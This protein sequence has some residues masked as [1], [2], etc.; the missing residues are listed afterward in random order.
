MLKN[1][2][3]GL[4]KEYADKFLFGFD[5][6]KL[7]MSLLTGNVD[8]KNVNIRPDA[9]N[10][11][12]NEQLK[13]PLSLKAGL[14]SKIHVKVSFPFQDIILY[15]YQYLTSLGESFGNFYKSN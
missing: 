6:D 10:E 7:S 13:L 15:K 14:L 1:K 11:I 9:I 8:L 12:L 3:Y 4:I 5:K 2:V